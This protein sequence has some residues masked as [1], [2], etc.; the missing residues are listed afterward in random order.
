VRPIQEFARYVLEEATENHLDNI[1]LDLRVACD[2]V[3]ARL[4]VG[5]SA[6]ELGALWTLTAM[7]KGLPEPAQADV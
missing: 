2:A 1:E 6:H 7:T 4:R 5:E 3:K